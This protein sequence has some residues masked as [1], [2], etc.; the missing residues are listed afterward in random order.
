MRKISTLFLLAVLALPARAQVIEEDDTTLDILTAVQGKEVVESSSKA[1]EYGEL[2][3]GFVIRKFK[4]DLG[5]EKN[6][7]RY[8]TASGANV[9]LN[10]ARYLLSLGEHGSYDLTIDYQKIPHLF[11]SAGVTIWSEVEPGRWTIPEAIQTTIQ[12]LNPVDPSDTSYARRI[13]D[14]RA[15]I[16]SMLSDAH[17]T[18]LGL[19]RNRGRVTFTKN[20]GTAWKHELEYFQENRDG[21][22]PIGTAFGFSWLT[23]LPEHID[24]D[25]ER[26]RFG[27]EYAK[28][29]KS[30]A[31]GYELSLFHHDQDV[32]IWDNP[33]RIDD[34]TY[35]RAYVNGDGTSQGRALLPGDNM[36]NTF[37]VAASANYGKSRVSGS[38]AYGLWSNSVDLLPFTI[39]SAIEEIP[40]PASTFD[41][42]IHNLKADVGYNTR[43]GRKLSLS[44]KYRL[45]DQRN[46][47]DSL[48]FPEYVRFDQ[49][50]EES[51][52][53]VLHNRN[54]DFTSNSIDVDAGW[55]LTDRINVRG[56]YGFNRFD[57]ERRDANSVD[58][59]TLRT[60]VDARAADWAT[61]RV[62]YQFSQR[63]FDEY[64]LE[65]TYEVIPLYRFDEANLN[66]NRVFFVSDLAI[67][68]K[69]SLGFTASWNNDDYLDTEFGVQEVKGFS[70]GADYSY[71]MSESSNFN[72]WYEHDERQSFQLGRQSGA[73]PSEDPLANW[74]ADIT[75]AYDT[76]GAG[77][78]RGFK[79]K[80]TWD[81]SASY[82]L[83]DGKADLFSPP[84]GTPDVAVG[85]SNS[86]D[87][88]LF[89]A[90]TSLKYKI[91]SRLQLGGY[92]WF[93]R[94]MI[95]DYAEKTMTP[96]LTSSGAI[97]LGATQPDYIYHL[98]WAGFTYLF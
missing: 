9:K 54:S 95:D 16:S 35:D 88:D 69:S 8:L 6:K 57:R 42:T 7:D 52:E 50:I 38:F 67:G 19:M 17:D 31:A 32:V 55:A 47:S 79:T 33:L 4:F 98:G 10:N 93:E 21:T 2:P 86:D 28:N 60:S 77:Y 29:G 78:A 90:R 87:T 80:W 37:N 64:E 96:D 40:L 92:Y 63:R 25:T 48:E 82:S 56:G 68:D 24:Y 22:R 30:F 84:G 41:G 66:R 83:A 15:Y 20:Q 14:Q 43:F 73:T 46:K 71:E 76:F 97:L 74:S 59:N 12:G 91:T 44:A 58:T 3:E 89:S 27:T 1:E 53:H 49:V 70:A 61:F 36:A 94:Y 62:S 5:F 81:I 85:F 65:G 26:M 75:D 51:S 45:H 34:R 72:I 23:E 11:S 18:P 39:N 13:A